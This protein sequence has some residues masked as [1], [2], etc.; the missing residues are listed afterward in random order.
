MEQGKGTKSSSSELFGSK[1]SSSSRSRILESI[2]PTQPKV[3]GGISLLT[4]RQNSPN[5]PL[6]ANPANSEAGSIYP[7]QCSQPCHL[8][9]SIYYGGQDV[10]PHPQTNQDSG[11]GSVYK[12][13]G[14]DDSGYAIRGNW[15]QGSLY[16]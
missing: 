5:E 14:E 12:D 8:S 2:F 6:N 13:D 9:S 16:Y 3:P 11:I 4:R 10:C 7:Q 1:V 15:W